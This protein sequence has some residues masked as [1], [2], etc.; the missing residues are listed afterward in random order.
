MK[1]SPRVN[2]S[3]GPARELDSLASKCE[4]LLRFSAA[5]SSGEKPI[6]SNTLLF[7]LVLFLPFC[8]LLSYKLK[9]FSRGFNL[10]LWRLV[11]RFGKA[12]QHINQSV[13][14]NLENSV[15]VL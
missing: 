7:M 14:R 8:G 3:D 4:R 2:D 10:L 9:S 5:A 1:R 13:Q 11:A 15:P 6:C 12:V